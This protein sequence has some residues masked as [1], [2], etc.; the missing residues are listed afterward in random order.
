MLFRRK[1]TEGPGFTLPRTE[2][3]QLNISILSGNLLWS[4][5]VHWE[6]GDINY[7]AATSAPLQTLTF[8]APAGFMPSRSRRKGQ[9][10]N[11]AGRWV[12]KLNPAKWQESAS[13]N[14]EQFL[15]WAETHA[16]YSTFTHAEL[17]I[18]IAPEFEKTARSAVL[19]LI[20]AHCTALKERGGLRVL[21]VGDTANTLL[22]E[23]CLEKGS[24]QIRTVSDFG[25]L[26]TSRE[27]SRAPEHS[28]FDIVPSEWA[29]NPSS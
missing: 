3:L 8:R 9:L 27:W 24:T 29:K 18:W 28:A 14:P 22:R 1:K 5:A 16:S 12:L 17:V 15:G 26:L 2:T 19:K 21:P 11:I 4:P 6:T 25:T 10:P 23:I 13:P 7:F 20:V